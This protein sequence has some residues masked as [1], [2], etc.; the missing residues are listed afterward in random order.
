MRDISFHIQR[1]LF[2]LGGVFVL[3]GLRIYY[4]SIIQREYHQR[5]AKRPALKTVVKNPNRG[6]IRDRFNIPMAINTI[7]YSISVIYDPIKAIPR[8][9]FIYE[10]GKKTCIYPRKEAISALASFLAPFCDHDPAYIEDIIYSKASL[11]PNTPFSLKDEISEDTYYKLK[12]KEARYP[13]LFMRIGQKRTYP[14]GKVGS[15]ILGYMGAIGE[16][17]HLAIKS[18]IQNLQTYLNNQKEDGLLPLPKGYSSIKQVKEDLTSLLNKSYTIHSKIGKNGI[19][20]QFDAELKGSIG[21]DFYL[22]NHKGSRRQKLPESY[23]EIPGRRV[24]L[25]ISAELQEYCEQ[26][27]ADS[28]KLRAEG[29]SRAGK[30]HHKIPAPWISGGA[31]IAMIPSTGEIVAMASFPTFDPN[32]FTSNSKDKALKWLETTS[33]IGKVF[34]GIYP[35]E[36][37]LYNVTT[38]EETCEKKELSYHFYLDTI[39]SKNS[40]IKKA[41]KK[42]QNIHTANFLQNCMEMLLSLSEEKEMQPLMDALFHKRKDISTFYQTSKEKRKEILATINSKTSLLEEIQTEITPFFQDIHKNDD[43]VLLLDL[44]RLFCPNHLFDDSLLA[45]TGKES[46]AVYKEFTNAKTLIENEVYEVVK[47][48]FHEHEF[49]DWRKAY[50]KEYLKGKRE[51]EKSKKRYAK[52]YLTYLQQIEKKLFLQ[53]FEINKWEFLQA[54]LTV[55]APVKKGDIRLPYFQALIKKSLEGTNPS[56][57]KLKKHLEKLSDAQIIPYLKTM[58]SYKE[59]GRNLYGKYYFPFKSGKKATEQDLARAFYPGSG[60]G[61]C[62]SAAFA[63]LLPLGSS[64]KVFVGYE[65]LADYFKDHPKRTFPLNPMTIIDKSPPYSAKIKKDTILGYH[66]NYS[67]IRRIYKGGRLPRGHQNIGEI[68][69]LSAMEKS[70]NLYYSLLTSDV[71]KDPMSLINTAKTLGFGKKTG[72]DLPFECRGAVPE[73]ILLNKTSLFSFAIGQ[74]S[75]IVTPLQTAVALSAFANNG[76][77]LKPQIVKAIANIEPTRD[78][79]N[80]LYKGSSNYEHAY[81]NI[82]V[83]FPLFPEGDEHDPSFY[84]KKMEKETITSINIPQPVHQTLMQSL[85]N[86]VNKSKGTARISA[87]G[88][89][90]TSPY[91]RSIYRKVMKS[92]AG[93]TSTAEIAYNPTLDR[94][95]PPIITKNIWF[96][97][98]SYP[99]ER[100]DSEPDLVVVV[101]LRFGPHGKEAAPLAASVIHKWREITKKQE[102]L[103]KK[104]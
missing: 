43:K 23:E 45:E 49:A 35:L 104:Q 21:K 64:F 50:F 92:M 80:L 74:H 56:Y 76:E 47:K 73:D 65:A 7:S 54:Y 28:E 103:A 27:L 1:L 70:S 57:Q 94:E 101:G 85:Y 3:F 78:P 81:K 97:A 10:N 12:M 66:L 96:T 36:K 59:L 8:R 95:Q 53:F 29:F 2:F 44:L 77:V 67:P 48:V 9:K 71:I 17:E 68:D 25:S 62:K 51:E 61:F 88:S 5:E 34:D 100:V 42:I 18:S 30:N 40:S 86:V 98:I 26:L 14:L 89:L 55:G 37:D 32:D 63:D 83:F 39:L 19:E 75:L 93:K 41:L 13:G 4:L 102:Q 52:P 11:F 69:F 31:I 58:R 91:K 79:L 90:I 22:V 60:F 6:T 15:H 33:H 99:E 20:K 46:L 38:K 82:G 24:L 87:I 72:I 84:L 16:K